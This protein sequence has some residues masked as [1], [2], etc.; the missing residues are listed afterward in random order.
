M[1]IWY[2]H[3]YDILFQTE[4]LFNNFVLDWLFPAFIVWLLYDF[5][6]GI[7]G[8]LYKSRV[9]KGRDI[10]SIIH[11]GIRYGIMWVTVQVLIYIRDNWVDILLLLGVVLI[12]VTLF[13]TVIKRSNK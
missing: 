11:W 7:V 4:P 6:F 8:G 12:V 5:T 10:G 3:V 2:K 9:I 1:V 13:A